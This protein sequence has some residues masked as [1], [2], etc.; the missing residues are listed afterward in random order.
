MKKYIAP[1]LESVIFDTEE[2][3]LTISV[4]TPKKYDYAAGALNDVM[5]NGKGIS[6][7][8]S[9]TVNLESIMYK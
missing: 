8:G 4:S 1:K 6:T 5:I 2:D 7:H 9:T 3:I